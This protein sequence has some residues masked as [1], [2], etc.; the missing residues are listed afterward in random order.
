M[1]IKV[2]SHNFRGMPFARANML[3]VNGSWRSDLQQKR[4]FACPTSTC[5]W[6]LLSHSGRQ[7]HAAKFWSLQARNANKSVRESSR[8]SSVLVTANCSYLRT[9]TELSDE[10]IGHSRWWT[11]KS[12]QMVKWVCK[13][14]IFRPR[15]LEVR[16]LSNHYGWWS[17]NDWDKKGRSFKRMGKYSWLG[18]SRFVIR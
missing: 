11:P 7:E 3:L 12:P 13:K 17:A 1:G 15:W 4:L 6:L 14:Q 5:S 10:C 16:K 18:K 8:G 2:G 9:M